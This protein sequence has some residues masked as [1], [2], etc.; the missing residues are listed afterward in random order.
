MEANPGYFGVFGK[1][2][3]RSKRDEEKDIVTLTMT[4]GD[5]R[6]LQHIVDTGLPDNP[7]N[8]LWG[9][10]LRLLKL[11]KDLNIDSEDLG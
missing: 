1:R 7:W 6:R 5:A 3:R 9:L 10:R 11:L 2:R 4:L 8:S